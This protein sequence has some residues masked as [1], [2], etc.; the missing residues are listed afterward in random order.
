MRGRCSIARSTACLC[1]GGAGLGWRGLPRRSLLWPAAEQI[2]GEHVAEALSY[3]SPREL[4][5]ERPRSCCVCRG[6]GRRTSWLRRALSATP[7][8]AESS[9]RRPTGLGW[10]SGSFASSGARLPTFP[11][12]CGAIHDPP[13]GLFLRGGASLQILG[14][15]AVAVV[16]ARACSTY[17]SQVAR[18]LAR[19]LAAAGV[20]VVSGMARGVD[21]EAHR[22]A[23]EAGGITVAVLGLRD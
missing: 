23:L 16:G 5:Y 7:G 12:F 19:D 17:G 8:F 13:A 14:A 15:R 11:C 22:G 4:G 20:V 2:A 10:R 21:G 6:N 9:T 3:R 1:R 18:V